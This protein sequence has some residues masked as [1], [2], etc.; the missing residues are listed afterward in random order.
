MSATVV[1]KTVYGAAGPLVFYFP[2]MAPGSLLSTYLKHLRPG[3]KFY[4]ANG[5]ALTRLSK[6]TKPWV[7]ATLVAAAERAE[8]VHVPSLEHVI[9]FAERDAA[10]QQYAD[11]LGSR[12]SSAQAALL[13]SLEAAEDNVSIV[14][15]KPTTLHFSTDLE[16]VREFEKVWNVKS[17]GD[18][19]EQVKEQRRVAGEEAGKAARAQRRHGVDALAA[20][21]PSTGTLHT[22]CKGVTLTYTGPDHRIL[23]VF[24]TAK[25]YERLLDSTLLLPLADARPE[26]Y[27]AILSPLSEAATMARDLP[28]TKKTLALVQDLIDRMYKAGILLTS[29][30]AASYIALDKARGRLYFQLPACMAPA[31]KSLSQKAH[32]A[33]ML[34]LITKAK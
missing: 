9:S 34:D 3:M 24:K 33:Q 10:K 1:F 25:L 6:T 7:L 20:E 11:W 15:V 12:A 19:A 13:R 4:C 22:S 31:P 23:A 8:R 16:H 17:V 14:S 27:A 18:S 5:T 21:F 2:K 32:S 28:R 26:V 29:P 30:E